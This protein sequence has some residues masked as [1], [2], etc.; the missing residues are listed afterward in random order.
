MSEKL[1]L[2]YGETLWDLLPAG[3]ELGG[4]PFNFAYRA[5]SLGDRGIIITRLNQDTLGRDAHERMLDLGMETTFVQWDESAPT[6]TVEITLDE[7]G[8]PDYYIVPNVAYDNIELNEPLLA[9]ASQAD[10]L[11]FGTLVQ[12]AAT[13]R[14]TLMCVLDECGECLKVL[15]I[16]LRKNCYTKET[17]S[18]SLER[19]DILKLNEQE[20]PFTAELFGFSTD[21]IPEFCS[22]R[23]REMVSFTLHGHTG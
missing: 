22:G 5:R 9:I 13:T 2:S 23:D 3:P 11:C 4:A 16:N 10:C 17:I 15:D 20:A 18:E 19:A 8:E 1:I 21:S 14:K 6:G 12:R 7:N